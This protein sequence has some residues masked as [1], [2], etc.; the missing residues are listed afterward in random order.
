VDQNFPHA[1]QAT[2][3][4]HLQR[5]LAIQLQKV[6][7]S[8]LYFENT[9]ITGMARTLKIFK[10]CRLFDPSRIDELG[11][12]PDA[13][14]A[15]LKHLPFFN[16]AKIAALMRQL[17]AYRATAIGEN[18]DDSVDREAWWAGKAATRGI[19]EWYSGATKIMVCQ[20]SSA[21]AERVFSMLKAVMGEQQ[22]ANALEDYQ[23]ATML[24]RYNGLMR[25]EL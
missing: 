7:R 19:D 15:Q 9:I 10:A 21:A 25:G 16:D 5:M 2:K 23:E 6:E 3:Q 11:A 12:E 1:L 4:G 24:A 22:Q 18:L 13:V 20:P 17:S 8:F 14:E